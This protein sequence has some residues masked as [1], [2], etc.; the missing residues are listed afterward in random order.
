MLS[1]WRNRPLHP[2]S[3]VPATMSDGRRNGTSVVQFGIPFAPPAW[4]EVQQM[5]DRRKQVDAAFEDVVGHLRVAG[6]EVTRRP[7][8]VE[9]EHRDARVLRTRLVLRAEVV[10]ERTVA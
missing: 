3:G 6:V 4:G 7:V 5:P 10:L 8:G 9:R 2:G 1:E